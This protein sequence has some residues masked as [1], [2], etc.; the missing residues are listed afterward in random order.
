M[1]SIYPD[2]PPNW[3]F[4]RQCRLIEIFPLFLDILELVKI[5]SD[6]EMSSISEVVTIINLLNVNPCI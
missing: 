1:M 2:Y 6:G 5:L 4:L 3:N